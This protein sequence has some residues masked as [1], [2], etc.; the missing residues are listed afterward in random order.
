MCNFFTPTSI[1]LHVQVKRMCTSKIIKKA[2]GKYCNEYNFR[3]LRITEKVSFNIASEASYLYKS[4]LKMPK[5][6]NFG[7]FL[8]PKACGQTVLP[9]MAILTRKKLIEN[10]KIE[11]KSNATFWVIFKQCGVL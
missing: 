1:D 2:S 9:V 10:A 11:K 5:M 7:E 3:C 4:L 8:K 6:A